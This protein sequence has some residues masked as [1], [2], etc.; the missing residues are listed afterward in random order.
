LKLNNFNA[1][2]T[3]TIPALVALE[4]FKLIFVFGLQQLH[5]R[6]QDC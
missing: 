6:A 4:A 2:D 3:T 1:I 5:I